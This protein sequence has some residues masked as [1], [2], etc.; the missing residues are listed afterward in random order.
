[1]DEPRRHLVQRLRGLGVQLLVLVTT[2][3]LPSPE[4][5][6]AMH[7]VNPRDVG[8]SLRTLSW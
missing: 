8:T 4:E 2:P 1:M 7:A 5:G 3:E 6:V